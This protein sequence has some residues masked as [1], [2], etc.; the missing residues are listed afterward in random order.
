MNIPLSKVKI[1]NK[2]EKNNSNGIKQEKK[3]GGIIRR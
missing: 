1:S 3:G 2:L